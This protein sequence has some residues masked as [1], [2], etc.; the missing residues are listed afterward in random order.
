MIRAADD[1]VA[2]ITSLRPLGFE[3]WQLSFALKRDRVPPLAPLAREVQ[4]VLDGTVVSAL[5]VYGNPLREDAVG[6][7]SRRSLREAMRTA[8]LFG[9]DIIGCFA[10]RVP[11][12]SV[13]SSLPRFREVWSELARE[14]EDCGVRIA[15]ENCL[16]GGT[17]QS[18]DWNIAINP[19]AWERMF[20]AVPADS[21][22]L[23][24]E[25]AHQLCQLIDPLPQL[26]RW[27]SRIFHLHGKDAGV[28][29]DI[30]AQHGVFGSER[31]AWHRLPGLGE[32]DWHDILRTLREAGYCGTIDI[33][34]YHD[35]VFKGDREIEGQLNALHYLK[36]C[37]AKCGVVPDQKLHFTAASI[38]RNLI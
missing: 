12:V 3:C 24:W 13:D 27:A 22:G 7:E 19:N 1:A 37:R 38:P 21:L 6:E 28:H 36:A 30:L 8:A 10:G 4:R 9:A 25:P 34:G 31:F 35:P 33:E 15:F 20:D 29:R 23:E 16:Q 11:G 2:A 32:T 5:G 26:K 14:A 17:W 18:G